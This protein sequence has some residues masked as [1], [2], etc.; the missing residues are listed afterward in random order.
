LDAASTF[1]AKENPLGADEAYTYL[2]A[3]LDQNALLWFV[4]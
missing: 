3:L 2:H 1:A 4:T